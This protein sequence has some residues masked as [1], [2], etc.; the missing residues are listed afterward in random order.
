MTA[1]LHVVVGPT[2]VGKTGYALECAEA[3][4]AEIVSADASVVYR[5]MDIGTA[6][7][8]PEERERAPHHLIDSREVDE[9]FDIVAYAAEAERAVADIAR[10]GRDVVVAGGS[11]LYLKSFFAPVVDPVHV[12][13][14]VRRRVAELARREGLEGMVRELRALNPEGLGALDARN[15]RRV[16]RAL[17]RCLASGRTLAALRA[18]F[19][20]QPEPY[21]DYAKR[22]IRLDRPK[23]ELDERIARRVDAM[24]EAGLVD[25][26]AALR[27]RGLE[28]NPSAAS[29][30]GYRETLAYLRGEL[31][32]EALREA[33]ARNTRRL[34][35]KQRTFFRRQLPAPER[36]ERP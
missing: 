13:A 27:E 31:D 25:E 1:T 2:A 12:P 4:G 33:I 30:I 10:R 7:P 29:A 34:A 35:K 15:P 5:G 6:K 36:V 17:E 22:L 32:R 26:V 8:G 18:E 3:R 11:G 19:A 21:A 14:S 9:P 16:A 28:R 20:A 24:L 23:A